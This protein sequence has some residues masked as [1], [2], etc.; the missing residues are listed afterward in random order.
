M[1]QRSQGEYQQEDDDEEV[2]FRPEIGNVAFGSAV[3]G[4]AFTLGQ[5]AE[6]YSKKLGASVD[7]L[8]KALWGDYCFHPKVRSRFLTPFL[9]RAPPFVPT[10]CLYA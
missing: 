2:V 7:A 1:L 10:P 6:I 3:D 4:W 9:S 8:Q 5:F